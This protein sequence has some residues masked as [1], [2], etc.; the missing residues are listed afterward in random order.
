MQNVQT[1]QSVN[2][3]YTPKVSERQSSQS[4]RSVFG[5][6]APDC[7][8]NRKWDKKA[9]DWDN[10]TGP[11]A[12]TWGWWCWAGTVWCDVGSESTEGWHSPQMS[13]SAASPE[14]LEENVQSN[15]TDGWFLGQLKQKH[16]WCMIRSPVCVFSLISALSSLMLVNLMIRL[17]GVAPDVRS[18]SSPS[19]CC[20]LLG[21]FLTHD[22]HTP[23]THP[24]STRHNSPG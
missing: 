11:G 3:L 8:G 6:K 7:D 10:W 23:V 16:W 4:R 15:E 22:K 5:R 21:R 1:S 24:A 2:L 14:D 17:C 20:S 9:A 18:L 19:G 12:L 13:G